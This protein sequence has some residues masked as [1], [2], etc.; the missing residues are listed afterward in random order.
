MFIELADHLR[1]PAEHPEGILV[2]LPDRVEERSVREGQLGCPVCGSSFR[3]SDGEFDCGGTSP[4]LTEIAPGESDVLD[5][6]G[7]A[8]LAGL[9]G[10]GG[11]L[12][13]VGEVGRSSDGVR[14]AL[15]GVALVTVNP[16][17]GVRDAGQLSVL[18]G[19]R[20]A[21]KSSSMR[22]V[23]L[24]SGYAGDAGWAREALR[25]T[26]AGLRVVGRGRPPSLPDLEIIAS[27]G[28]WW[29]GSKVRNRMQPSRQ[30]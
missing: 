4:E 14:E 26:L 22:G 12:V 27:A 13:L 6:A 2:L 15:P 7:V 5:G 20:L 18:R 24:G 1:C 28:G 21:L 30:V 25:V 10:P 23:V 9:G 29:V 3:I 19:G 17:P 16:P 11:Y 8:A